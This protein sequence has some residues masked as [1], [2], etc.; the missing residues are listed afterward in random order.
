MTYMSNFPP[1]QVV[2]L[3]TKQAQ[4][5]SLH[6][7]TVNAVSSLFVQVFRSIPYARPPV[8]AMRW[9]DPLYVPLP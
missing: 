5:R 4:V 8:G 7:F 6:L 9:K 3:F 2:G 1:L